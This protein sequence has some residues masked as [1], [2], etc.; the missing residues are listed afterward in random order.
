[1]AKDSIRSG[2]LVTT[3]GPG[4]MVDLP[5][6]AVIVSGLDHWNYDASVPSLL[7]E[8]PRLLATL[9]RQL[10][11]PPSHLRKPPPSK[12]RDRGFCPNVTA[13]EFPE[14]FVVQR[15]ESI[16]GGGKQRR[17]VQKHQLEQGRFRD[18]H[19]KRQSVVPVRFVQSCSKGHVDDID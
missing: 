17:L 15:A 19:G 13:W 2:Q 5:D 11:N 4:S 3:F 9:R 1:M 8:E 10:D 18:D 14:W 6:S 12:D 16:A 7:V